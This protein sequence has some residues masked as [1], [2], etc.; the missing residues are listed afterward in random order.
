MS[1]VIDEVITEPQQASE[2]LYN[3]LDEHKETLGIAFLGID[4]RLKPEYPAVV[5]LSGGKTKEHHTNHVFLVNM[6]VFLMVYHARLDVTHSQRTKED[7]ELVTNIENIIESGEMNFGGR[8]VF[9]Y[10]SQSAP[11]TGTRRQSESVIGTQMIVTIESRKG[12]PYGP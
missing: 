10:I 2:F 3:L 9:A 12:F 8:I 1:S 11:I 6:E 4:E 5:V 7:L